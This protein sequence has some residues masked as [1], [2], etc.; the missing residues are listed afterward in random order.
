MLPRAVPEHFRET[1]VPTQGNVERGS[2]AH[3][4]QVYFTRFVFRMFA[5][6]Y[7]HEKAVFK[8]YSDYKFNVNSTKTISF[9]NIFA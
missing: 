8:N 4:P 5:C 3:A 6:N 2:M 9:Q 1:V 7:A